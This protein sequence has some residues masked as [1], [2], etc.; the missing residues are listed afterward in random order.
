MTEEKLECLEADNP[1]DPCSGDVAYRSTGRG[2]SFPRC[3]K[4]WEKRLER[5]EETVRRY[6]P[7]GV[8]PPAGF[9]PEY[10]GERWDDDY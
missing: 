4:H 2:R 9:D 7:Y 6:N 3:D 5:E 8:S 1:D 10:A